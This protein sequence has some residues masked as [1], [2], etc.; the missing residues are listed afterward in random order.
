MRAFTYVVGMLFLMVGWSGSARADLLVASFDSY[1]VLRYE[2]ATG[3]FLGIFATGLPGDRPLSMTVGPDGNLYVGMNNFGP[4]FESF[5]RRFDGQTGAFIDTF[6]AGGGL[7][8][9]G[10]LVFGPDG[11]LYVASF[12]PFANSKVIR[13][14]GITGAYIDDFVQVGS[15]G[16]LGAEGLVFGPDGNLYVTSR[17]TNQVLRYDGLTGAFLGVFAA[18]G[19]NGPIDL[20]F[21][22][23]GNLYVLNN[24]ST[25]LEVLRFDGLTGA[26]IDVF[27]SAFTGGSDGSSLVFGRDGNLY[28]TT[29]FIGNSVWRFNGSTGQLIDTFVS[30]G[31]GGL[32]YATGLTFSTSTPKRISIDIKPASFPNNINPRS[33]GV[34]PVAILTTDSFDATTVDW[35]TVR[36]GAT[37]TEAAPVRF[38]LEDVDGDGDID[39]ILHFTTQSTGIAC[40]ETSASLTGETFGG[41][42]IQGADSIHTV[43]C[44]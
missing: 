40:G 10:H 1:Q 30:S 7:L 4:P 18:V 6:A 28:V 3:A 34:I 42:M 31:S 37:G 14:N 27:V 16:L 2:D 9:P 33:A 29:A 21:G 36:F 12:G 17:V 39:M 8:G 15:G 5:I 35:T 23:D 19:Q 43:G 11:N 13:Y 44:H 41:Q 22:P 26:F 20:V 38:A 32:S 24:P 25:N